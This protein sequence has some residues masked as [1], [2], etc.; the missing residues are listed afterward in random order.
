MWEPQHVL[1]QLGWRVVMPQLRGFDGGGG[2]MVTSMDDYAADIVDLLDR[3]QID[4][5]VIGGLSMGGYVAFALFRNAPRYFRG[6]V[7]ADTRS[8]ADTPEAAEGRQRMLALVQS[9][10]AGAVADELL[11][12]LLGETTRRERPDVAGAVR[13]LILSSPNEATAAAIVALK[14]RPDS[15]PLLPTIHLPT[16]ILVG[17]EDT[18]T[19]PAF[20]ESMHKAIAGSTLV[21]IPRAGHMANLEQPQAF[22]EAVA[23]F[24]DR[25]V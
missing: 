23:D 12:K 4:E 9:K 1:S 25:R 7:L 6:L 19:P 5:A 24:L 21:T 18:L 10:G 2:P 15:T 17:E 3:L 13:E 22:N 20:S 14:N 8:L 11:P 16:L